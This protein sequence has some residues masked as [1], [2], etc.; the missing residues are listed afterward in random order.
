MQP[1][2]SLGQTMST[3]SIERDL[4]RIEAFLSTINISVRSASELLGISHTTLIRWLNRESDPYE[5]SLESVMDRISVFDKENDCTGL[6]RRIT[7]MTHKERVEELN[8][9]LID[10]SEDS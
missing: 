8:Q 2:P 4:K 5:W 9:A 10:Y 3:T 7:A 1:G 6:Y